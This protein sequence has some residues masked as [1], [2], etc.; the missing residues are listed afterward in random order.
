MVQAT[1]EIADT[2]LTFAVCR[3]ILRENTG[4]GGACFNGIPDKAG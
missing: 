3:A 2:A 1:G 4:T